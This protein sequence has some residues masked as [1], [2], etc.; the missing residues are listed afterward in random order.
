MSF[1]SGVRSCI[2]LFV[3]F[4]LSAGMS[5]TASASESE[6]KDGRLYLEMG[7]GE[8]PAALWLSVGGTGYLDERNSFN[9]GLYFLVTENIIDDEYYNTGLTLSYRHNL[10]ARGALR[11]FIGVGG[12]VGYTEHNVLAEN[13][14]IDNDNDGLTDEPGEEINL[15]SNEMAMLFP[16]VGLDIW[17]TKET[18]LSLSARYY[19]TTEGRDVDFWLFGAAVHF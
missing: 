1:Q 17:M 16:E 9:M 11:P 13:D 19:L 8:K 7:A 6:P 2:C 18:K 15:T 10:T 3:C 14:S 4:I 12:A 5:A